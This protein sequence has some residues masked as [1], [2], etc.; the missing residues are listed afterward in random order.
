MVGN[1]EECICHV[2]SRRLIWWS[3]HVQSDP[4]QLNASISCQMD[5]AWGWQTISLSK[6]D[7]GLAE[8]WTSVA[9]IHFC[10]LNPHMPTWEVFTQCQDLIWEEHKSGCMKVYFQV[11]VRMALSIVSHMGKQLRARNGSGPS[12]S[13]DEEGLVACNM[14]NDVVE[15]TYYHGRPIMQNMFVPERHSVKWAVE[16]S[17]LTRLQDIKC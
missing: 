7:N 9:N 1:S 2:W 8:R 16:E 15:C 5:P 6:N 11:A 14:W 12:I 3:L 4:E 17:H 10:D 13:L